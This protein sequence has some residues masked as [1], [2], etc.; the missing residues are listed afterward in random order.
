[1]DRFTFS[2]YSGPED[3]GPISRAVSSSWRAIGPDSQIHVG[4]LAWRLTGFDLE[5]A[6]EDIGIWFAENGEVASFT[7]YYRM[8]PLDLFV[9]ADVE[10][11]EVLLAAMLDWAEG[12]WLSRGHGNSSEAKLRV[13][14]FAEDRLGLATLKS[15]GY[16]MAGKTYLR[17]TCPITGEA[18]PDVPSDLVLS[19]LSPSLHGEGVTRLHNELFPSSRIEES[20]VRR[21]VSSRW[22]RTGLSL[23]AEHPTQGVV[24]FVFGWYDPECRTLEFEPVGC[25]ADWRRRGVGRALLLT[26]MAK[27]REAGAE[28]A[29]VTAPGE[30][31]ATIAFYRAVGF[32]DHAREYELAR[33]MA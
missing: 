27:A 10:S 29:S 28:R 17:L 6:S 18:P 30:N 21:A 13:G 2:S 9:R 26:V 1:M 31:E 22:H 11:R 24:G 19:T 8:F 5:S 15:R 7:A 4:N 12:R 25:H 20:K 3:L 16:E 23:V 32:V 14:C 33:A